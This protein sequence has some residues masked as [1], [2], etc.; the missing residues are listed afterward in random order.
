MTS[1]KYTAQ[2]LALKFNFQQIEAMTSKCLIAGIMCKKDQ[3]EKQQKIL[4]ILIEA[5]QIKKD[6]K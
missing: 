4:N 2:E 5:F 3:R 1:F 6:T